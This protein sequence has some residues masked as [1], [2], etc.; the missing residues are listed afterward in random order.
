MQSHVGRE[1]MVLS[2]SL[3]L[4]HDGCVSRY[5]ATAYLVPTIPPA[6]GTSSSSPPG[7]ELRDRFS[8]FITRC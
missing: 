8:V 7:R 6:A 5:F 1:A 3:L 2:F 4:F